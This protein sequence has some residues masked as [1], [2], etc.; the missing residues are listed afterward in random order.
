MATIVDQIVA[1]Q[2]QIANLAAAIQGSSDNAKI[3]LL[4]GQ[5]CVY[6]CMIQQGAGTGM[7]L[8][9][10]GAAS[11]DSA[12]LNPSRVD[13]NPARI[14]QYG[15]AAAVYA[16]LFLMA[17]ENVT[18]ITDTNLTV[19]TAPGTGYHRYDAVY[20]YVGV[21]GPALGI[22]AGT[23]VLNASTPTLPAIPQGTLILAQVHVQAGV[24]SITNANITDLRNF[25]TRL[26]C[27]TA[28]LVTNPA[29]PA[30]TSVGTLVSLST[31][32]QI[33]SS[34]S[35]GTAPFVVA[36]TTPVVNLSI[37]G[38][39]AT[40]TT[41]ANLT[42]PITSVGNATS[43]ASQTGT[44]ST[45]VMNTSPTL[46]T[47]NIG[48][49]TGTS[50]N[51]GAGSLTAG[52]GGFTTLTASSSLTLNTL[53]GFAAINVSG[54]PMTGS[55]ALQISVNSASARAIRITDTATGG[56]V[57]DITTGGATVLGSLGFFDQTAY[58]LFLFPSDHVGINTTTD[59][60]VDVLQVNGSGKFNG[61][62][63]S[64]TTGGTAFLSQSATTSYQQINLQNTSGG[65]VIGMEGSVGGTLIVGSAPYDGAIYARNGVLNFSANNGATKSMV[66]TP[67][68]L[69]V[70][71]TL[72]ASSTIQPLTTTVAALP[73]AGT[74]GREAVVTDATAPTD[75]G[76]LAGGGTVTTPVVD[77]GTAWV[78]Y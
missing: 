52:A 13:P 35:T 12:H 14:E 9:I 30:I 59:N 65:I 61:L 77:N 76:G 58:R 10:Q 71:G 72:T 5:N 47:P 27:A 39:A 75:L 62:I 66:L 4:A 56:G 60:G 70:T 73:A 67:S 48:A 50:L 31:A 51:L 74:K 38:N 23:A 2:N 7:T 43:V 6:G 69:A 19:T 45:F 33:T 22:A 34:V 24:T 53:S 15:N 8:S 40:V 26:S 78:A 41:N 28:G 68:G 32:G 57:W 55:S 64:T 54:T 1:Q 36:S 20:C 18:T 17:D 42:G 37:G 16:G 3:Y 21:A 25:N 49:A 63:T 11:G 29:Q 44:G 46:V